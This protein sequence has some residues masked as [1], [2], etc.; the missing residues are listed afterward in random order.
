MT[1]LTVSKVCSDF[2]DFIQ[3]KGAEGILC[4][5]SL[6]EVKIIVA[7]VIVVYAITQLFENLFGVTVVIQFSLRH[8][9]VPCMDLE[10][11]LLLSESS[12]VLGHTH[13]NCLFFCF[14]SRALDVI[15]GSLGREEQVLVV[16]G[17]G[18]SPM[19]DNT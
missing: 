1:I 3:E 14:S 19:S 12:L 2:F 15:K 9:S 18:Q 16:R 10:L 7:C 4:Q 6:G 13:S 8:E 11:R 17:P 5:S